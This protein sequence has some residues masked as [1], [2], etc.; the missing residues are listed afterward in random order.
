MI[1]HNID[2]DFKGKKMSNDAGS[3]SIDKYL[4]QIKLEQSLETVFPKAPKSPSRRG[5]KVEHPKHQVLFQQIKSY[6]KGY[7]NPTE[8]SRTKNDPMHNLVQIPMP[9]Q[10]T[11]SRI[12]TNY[13]KEDCE[14]LKG[15]NKELIQNYL[16]E[17]VR[18][19][20]G[21]KLEILEIS[22]DSSKIITNGNQEG[23]AYISHYKV[24]GYHPD[25]ITEDGMRLIME[26]VLRNG[27]VY[28]SKGSELLLQEVIELLAPFTKKIVF[29]GDSAY[30]KPEI[31]NKLRN[32]EGLEIEYY[33]KEKTYWSWLEKAKIEIKY[34]GKKYH[35]LELP[36]SYFE[37]TDNNGQKRHKLRYFVFEHQCDTWKNPEKIVVQMKY[38]KEGE[39]KLLIKHMDKDI[40]LL[41]TNADTKDERDGKMAFKEYGKR[42]KQE[43]IIEE[44]KNDSHGKTLSHEKKVQ[45]ACDFFLK[46]IAHNLMQIMR[47]ETLK[48]TKYAKC[49]IDTMRRLFVNVGGSIIRKGGKFLIHLAESFAYKKWYRIVMERIPLIKFRLC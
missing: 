3:I 8:M 12:H 7:G 24:V 43:Q 41:I 20:G 39:Q 27:N 17:L 36:K 37:E 32:P 38:K 30:A 14:I 16:K 49:R 33:I 4:G 47:L 25:F 9:S 45:N 31:L 48:G 19:K 13:T 26:G 29:R 42:G 34:H 28:S 1:I 11:F 40:E 6:M 23:S 10:P 5:R 22:D 15:L 46:I 2:F 18:Q 21:E 35:P 44:F